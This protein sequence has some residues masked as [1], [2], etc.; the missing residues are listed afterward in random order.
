MMAFLAFLRM[1]FIF[2]LHHRIGPI[3]F[4][5]KNVFWDILSIMGSYFIT[6]LAFSVGLV[7]VFG[8]YHDSQTHFSNFQSSLKRLFWIIFDPGQEELTDIERLNSGPIHLVKNFSKINIGRGL[9]SRENEF[10]TIG[11]FSRFFKMQSKFSQNAV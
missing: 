5:I 7:S 11:Q 8:V 4:C 10:A 2:E 3:L 1:I 6:M 9:P